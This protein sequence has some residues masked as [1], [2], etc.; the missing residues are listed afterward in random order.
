[1]RAAAPPVD[2]E[3]V[4]AS[5]LA[6][7]DDES[8]AVSVT[9]SD[10]VVGSAEEAVGSAEESVAVADAADLLSVADAA[11]VELES[12]SVVVAVES[13]LEVAVARVD[14]ATHAAQLVLTVTHEYPSWQQVAPV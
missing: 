7:E 4:L 13:P 2:V 5:L 6:S 3:M 14:S 9:E 12:S 8:V 1:M 10:V 11:S